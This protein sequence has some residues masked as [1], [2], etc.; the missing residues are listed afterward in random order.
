MQTLE[1]KDA[2]S[3]FRTRAEKMQD[4]ADKREAVLRAAV[5]MFNAHGFHATSLDDVAASLGI[6]KPTIYHYL[7]NKEQVLIECVTRGLEPLR[8]AA[9]QA[10]AQAGS[11]LERLRRFL[12]DY[13]RTNMDDFGRC[14]VRTGDELLSP[15]S[16][17]SIRAR[18]REI[19]ATLRALIA[20]GIADGSIAPVDVKMSAFALAGALNWPARWHDPAGP[21]SPET[22]ATGL[23]DMLIGGLAPR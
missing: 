15:A 8:S 23:V 5:R 19:D 12:I 18:K 21:D 22:I 4:R 14:M 10:R 11:G 13:A 2:P 9:E 20:E 16:A 17:A 3:P 1:T 6:S 7:G